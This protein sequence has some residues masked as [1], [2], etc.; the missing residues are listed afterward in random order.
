MRLRW[1]GSVER[2]AG[3]P[4]APWLLGAISFAS[5]AFLPI[6]PDVLLVPMALVQPTR[7]WWLTLQCTVWAT[8][9]A[10]AGYVIGAEFWD[11]IGQR[12]IE[13]YGWTQHFEAFQAAFAKWGVWIII[14]KALTPIPFKF[15]AIAAGVAKM[16]F[17]TFTFA[18]LVSRALHFVLIAAFLQ[19]CG[20]RVMSVIEKYETRAAAAA[21]VALA[22]CALLY[23][24]LKP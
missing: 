16:N 14:L 11:L 5:S 23:V 6:A 7:L 13:L 15:A 19:W 1:I 18:S 17:V 20:E 2:F 22:A 10:L 4:S 12:L 9:G 8:L 3:H 24:G 21:L